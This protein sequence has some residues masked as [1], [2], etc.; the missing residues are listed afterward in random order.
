MFEIE[1][2]PIRDPNDDA[3]N[4]AAVVLDV[5]LKDGADAVR[6]PARDPRREALEAA[7]IY[8][9]EQIEELLKL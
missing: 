6:I 8:S 2:Q 4:L 1:V 3:E 5:D 7:K 9:P